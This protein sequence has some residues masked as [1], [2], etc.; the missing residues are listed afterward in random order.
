MAYYEA[1][2]REFLKIDTDIMRQ[3]P[4]LGS[5]HLRLSSVTR[6]RKRTKLLKVT[7]PRQQHIKSQ[8]GIDMAGGTGACLAV[9]PILFT[10][11]I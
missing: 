8:P 2:D 6:F 4:V 1:R 9:N 10:K 7:S 5:D 3:F 11:V